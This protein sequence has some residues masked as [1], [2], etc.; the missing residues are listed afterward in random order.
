MSPYKIVCSW[1]MCWLVT[2]HSS[3]VKGKPSYCI[4]TNVTCWP[5]ADEIKTFTTKLS[6]QLLFPDSP[7]YAS[8]NNVTNPRTLAYPSFIVVISDVNDIQQSVLFAKSHNIQ[9]SIISTGHSYSGAN[10]GNNTLQINL[11]NMKNYKISDDRT[12][13]TVETGLPWGEIYPIVDKIDKIIVGGGDPT[14]GPGGYA[15]GGGHSFLTPL[16][17]LASDFITELYLVDSNG[18]LIHVTNQTDD[19]NIK[20]SFWAIR[21]G[22]GST[23]GVTVNITFQL[24]DPP[25]NDYNTNENVFT[26]FSGTFALYNENGFKSCLNAMFNYSVNYMDN[27]VG[28]YIVTAF[29]HDNETSVL[30]TFSIVSFIFPYDLNYTQTNINRYLLNDNNFNLNKYKLSTS[31]TP[32]KTF[33]EYMQTVQDANYY[34]NFVFNDFIPK[35]NITQDFVNSMYDT[36]DSAKKKLENGINSLQ[37]FLFLLYIYFCHSI[38]I[39]VC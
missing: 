12:T 31:F 19:E 30:N 29:V 4:P 20:D 11:K 10:T 28:G 6:G 39:C 32:Y 16:F 22:G 24:H 26:V 25:S 37:F 2:L 13:I 15:M 34:R 33:W 21:G 9:I 27:N 5:S 35:Q 18:T 38:L 3:L 8:Y 17:G 36:L 14:V 7:T 23:F 1:F